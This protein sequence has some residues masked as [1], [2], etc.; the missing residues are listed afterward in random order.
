MP[1][2]SKE[3]V[4]ELLSGL[5]DRQGYDLED[6]TVT[7]AGKH[8]VV[9]VMV[10]GDAGLE[11]DAVAELSRV[12]SDAFDAATEFGETPYTLE[13]TSP[14]VDR[15]L[16][17]PRHWRRARGR[18]VAVQFADE[19]LTGRVGALGDGVVALVLPGKGG[20]TVREIALADVVKAVVQV[21]F[22]K[23]NPAELELAGGVAEGRVLPT[24]VDDAVDLTAG[25]DETDETDD[26]F[27]V[28]G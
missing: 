11:L 19:Q 16:T 6:V 1:V 22:S 2:P 25:A 18:K 10:D 7:Q 9:R 24:D 27:Q 15:P 13:V 17:E 12:I 5:V 14:G 3:R 28:E 8:S 26:E 21:E 20:P 4:V 23:P